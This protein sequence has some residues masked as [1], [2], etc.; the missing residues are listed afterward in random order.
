MNKID[1]LLGPNGFIERKDCKPVQF[2]WCNQVVIV[3]GRVLHQL[4]EASSIT[5]TQEHVIFGNLD[6]GPGT[7][8]A[9]RWA[10]HPVQLA[11]FSAGV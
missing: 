5:L 11:Q 9:L 8:F 4:N 3:H 1:H 6:A 7:D 2:L 10:V